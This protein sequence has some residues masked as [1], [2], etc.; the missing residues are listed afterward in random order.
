MVIAR[1]V[2]LV[3]ACAAVGALFFFGYFERPQKITMYEK[4]T[5]LGTPV[6]E[7]TDEQR[8]TLRHRG[9]NQRY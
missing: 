5:Y 2:V 3:L 6:T 9:A 7:L 8:A 1:L 4:G